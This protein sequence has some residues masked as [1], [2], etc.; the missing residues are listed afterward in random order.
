MKHSWKETVKQTE[1]RAETVVK[2]QS[3]LVQ[4]RFQFTIRIIY[5]CLYLYAHKLMVFIM[6]WMFLHMELNFV[7]GYFS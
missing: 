6:S 2:I 4:R 3:L 5:M 1:Q 7:F